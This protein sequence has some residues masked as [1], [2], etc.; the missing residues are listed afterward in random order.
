MHEQHLV[1]EL[2]LI[3][4]LLL[5]N[6]CFICSVLAIFLYFHWNYVLDN[7]CL[8]C[9]TVRPTPVLGQ[10]RPWGRVA[11]GWS[12][13]WRE[14]GAAA[15]SWSSSSSSIATS[16]GQHTRYV[17]EPATSSSFRF[18]IWMVTWATSTRKFCQTMKTT[19]FYF[20]IREANSR[21]WSKNR[22]QIVMAL[23]VFVFCRTMSWTHGLFL[24]FNM[25][26]YVK[27]VFE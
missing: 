2:H 10:A 25:M 17:N 15:C 4:L 19:T 18:H 13:W 7:I 3:N 26:W 16:A 23:L 11:V 9:S 20:A 22:V 1:L 27:L 12:Y 21:Q 5:F 24:Q 14:G 6:V 8:F